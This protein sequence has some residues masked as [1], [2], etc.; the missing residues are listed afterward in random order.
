VALGDYDD[1][2]DERPHREPLPLDDRLWR[3]PSEL[4]DATPP[5]RSARVG[6]LLSSLFA[7][8]RP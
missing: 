7:R 3:H 8:Q 1:E 2:L 5:K 4:D 6:K